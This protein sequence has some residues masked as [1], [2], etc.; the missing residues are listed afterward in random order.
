MSHF[1]QEPGPLAAPALGPQGTRGG[2][3]LSPPAKRATPRRQH[4]ATAIDNWRANGV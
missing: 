2:V 4:R 1:T 3:F